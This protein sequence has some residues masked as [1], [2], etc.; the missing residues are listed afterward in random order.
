MPLEPSRLREIGGIVDQ[1]Y[2]RMQ[3]LNIP[4]SLVNGDINLDNILYDG[5]KFHFTDWAE[6]GIGNPFLTLQQVIQHVTREG[7][8]LEWVPRLCGAYKKKW[9]VLLT[10][11]QIE[12]AFGLMPLL[13]MADYLYGRGDWL[14]S[15][16]RDDSSFQ[17]FARTL[18]RCMDRAAAELWSAEVLQA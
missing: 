4:C 16:R 9:L 2:E 5:T 1:A 10:E 8:K 11:R 14:H 7:E 13:T 6:G 15:S 12:C 18:A 17:G 3:E